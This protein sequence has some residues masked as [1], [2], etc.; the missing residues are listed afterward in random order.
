MV[1]AFF[2]LLFAKNLVSLQPASLFDYLTVNLFPSTSLS[3]TTPAAIS[4]SLSVLLVISAVII[5]I[6]LLLLFDFLDP[7]L[8]SR[9]TQQFHVVN[10]EKFSN[11]PPEFQDPQSCGGEMNL[12]SVVEVKLSK[13]V[14]EKNFVSL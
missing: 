4:T 2:V 6:P 5:V 8:P 7:R 11:S 10:L 1:K 14:Y 13:Q 9:V 12:S 3:F